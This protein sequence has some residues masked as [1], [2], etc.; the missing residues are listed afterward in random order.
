MAIPFYSFIGASVLS[1]LRVLRYTIYIL[2]EYE[3]ECEKERR[4]I[5]RAKDSLISTCNSD[6]VL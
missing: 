3:K 1:K 4:G 2:S 5:T 6:S